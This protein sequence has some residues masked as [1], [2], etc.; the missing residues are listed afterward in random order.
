MICVWPRVKRPEPCVRGMTDD[1]DLDRADLRRGP[2]VRATLVDRDLL[3]DEALVDRLARLLDVALRER[4]LDGGS[5]STVA[6]PTGKGSLTLSTICSKSRLR[7]A[8]LS[9]FESC[10]ASVRPR[11]SFS[12][13]SRT[14]VSTATERCFSR[15]CASDMRVCSSPK[16]F[17]CVG[18]QRRSADF[19]HD[20]LLDDRGGLAQALLLDALPDLVAVAGL[21]AARSTGGSSHFGLPRF[22]RSSCCAS[23]SFTISRWA[24]SSASRSLSSCTWFAP[25]STIVRPSFVPTTIRSRSDVFDLLRA[26]G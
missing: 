5:P 25:A 16:T 24:I 18:V 26:S 12:N 1:L 4:V 13:C 9:S 22:A 14:A 10:S 21:R 15:I 2:A 23:Q 20:D 8:D 17:A 11:S 7:L 19:L 3:A 6:G